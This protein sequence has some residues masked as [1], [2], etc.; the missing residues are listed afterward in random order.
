MVSA[1]HMVGLPAFPVRSLLWPSGGI[2]GMGAGHKLSHLYYEGLSLFIWE[3]S[4]ISQN[5]SISP[6]SSLREN[7]ET[8]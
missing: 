3:V 1:G 4:I 2:A 6:E 7:M 8:L 5:D